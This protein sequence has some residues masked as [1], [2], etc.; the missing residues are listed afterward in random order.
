MKYGLEKYAQHQKLWRWRNH[1]I[2][3]T[4]FRNIIDVY[5]VIY[6]IIINTIGLFK[7]EVRYHNYHL[8]YSYNDIQG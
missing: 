8:T 2:D 4:T 5:A 6:D 1:L 7:D 3:S